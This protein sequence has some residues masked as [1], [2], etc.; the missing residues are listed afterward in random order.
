MFNFAVRTRND[1]QYRRLIPR[2]NISRD[3]PDFVQ[4]HPR[5]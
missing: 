3:R 2:R 1:P 4:A 5:L